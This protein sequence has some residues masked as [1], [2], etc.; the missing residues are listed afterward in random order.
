MS[1]NMILLMDFEFMSSCL[2]FLV[3]L[4]LELFKDIGD[5]EPLKCIVKNLQ[6]I[7]LLIDFEFMSCCLVFLGILDL[8]LFKDI[9]DIEPLKCVVKNLEL[10]TVI[11]KAF[12]PSCSQD[13]GKL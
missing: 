13:G 7:M 4:N 5:I 6:N 8:E 10:F 2:V 9:R 1:Q 3:I 11:M 12:S